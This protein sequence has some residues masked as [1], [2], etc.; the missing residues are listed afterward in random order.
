MAS[1]D[2]ATAKWVQTHLGWR[3]KFPTF[4]I[5]VGE[6]TVVKVQR[7]S[8]AVE[9]VRVQ[10]ADTLPGSIAGDGSL[11][12]QFALGRRLPDVATTALAAAKRA[13]G[14]FFDKARAGAAA[15][16]DFPLDELAELTG[17]DCLLTGE[18]KAKC[19]SAAE[20]STLAF[21]LAE[22]RADKL[23]DRFYGVD[24]AS[25]MDDACD[26]YSDDEFGLAGQ[27][28]DNGSYRSMWVAASD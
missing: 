16:A 22:A 17:D 5:A 27:W 14:T 23:R 24:L 2:Y 4:G 20:E 19:R 28:D 26:E 18:A 13:D 3:V 15:L 12:F 21:A 11:P 10:V 8:G 1:R 25:D 9:D 7:S 6:K